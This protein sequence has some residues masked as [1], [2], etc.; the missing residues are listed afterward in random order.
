[1]KVITETKE[2]QDEISRVIKNRV[3][4]AAEY[5]KKMG[6]SANPSELS[7][8]QILEIRGLEE[9]KQAGNS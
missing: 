2:K 8:E 6:W 5:C 9:W 4:I 3:E 1:M 7:F